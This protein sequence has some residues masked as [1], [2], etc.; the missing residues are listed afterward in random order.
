MKHKIGS[1]RGNKRTYLTKAE[2]SDAQERQAEFR[3]MRKYYCHV[4]SGYHLTKDLKPMT[5]KKPKEQKETVSVMNQSDNCYRCSG[6]GE[7]YGGRI[8]LVCRGSGKIC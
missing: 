5:K 6:Y 4:C 1:C 2:V 3:Y 8:C 7:T